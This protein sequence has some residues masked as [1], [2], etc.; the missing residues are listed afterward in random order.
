MGFSEEFRKFARKTHSAEMKRSM[1]Y[2]GLVAMALLLAACGPRKAAPAAAPR[3]FP[4]PDI[5]GMYVDPGDRAEYFAAHFWD[6]FTDTTQFFAGDTTQVNGVART[7]LEEKMGLFATIASQIPLP[8]GEK[9]MVRLYERVEAFDRKYP[10]AGM[11]KRMTDLTERYFYDPQSP[12]RNEDLFQPV[13]ARMAVSD[14]VPEARRARYGFVARMARLNR[15]GTRAANFSFVDSRGRLRTLYSIDAEHLLLIFGNPDC[16]ACRD[17][18]AA[19]DGSLPVSERIADG[20]LKVLDVY[21]DEEIEAWKAH[22]P[23]YPKTWINGYDPTHSLRAD[24]TYN[25][26]AIPSLYLLDRDKTV[27]LKDAPQERLL[28]CLVRL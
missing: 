9:A 21:I 1:K 15:V 10:E 3:P 23:D 28:D 16:A 11:Y 13:A 27:L 8:S 2:S 4:Q 24:L 25:V 17:L 5:P 12:V 18:V 22:I 19:M 6:R 26:R 20:R 14:L 7:E